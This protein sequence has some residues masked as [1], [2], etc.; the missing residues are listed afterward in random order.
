MR[1]GWVARTRRR[2]G[3][4]DAGDDGQAGHETC[5]RDDQFAA[6]DFGVQ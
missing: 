2:G 1:V 3:D 5:D 4:T 6:D